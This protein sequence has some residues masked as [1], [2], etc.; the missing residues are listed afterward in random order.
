MDISSQELS[1]QTYRIREN[2]NKLR[3]AIA[4]GASQEALLLVLQESSSAS[5][6]IR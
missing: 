5:P 3:Q 6:A 2:L 4:K 1:S